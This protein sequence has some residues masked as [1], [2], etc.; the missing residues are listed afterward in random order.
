MHKILAKTA[1]YIVS[2]HWH[3]K[4]LTQKIVKNPV[5]SVARPVETAQWVLECISWEKKVAK[6]VKMI[7]K[8]YGVFFSGFCREGL[9]AAKC[10]KHNAN[11]CR[12]NE[13]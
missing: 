4:T 8:S 10:G 5:T 11:T 2:E 9:Y 7:A 13:T 3:S 12:E 6:R 1:L